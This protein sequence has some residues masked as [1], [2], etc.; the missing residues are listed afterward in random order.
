MQWIGSVP[1]GVFSLRSANSGSGLNNRHSQVICNVEDSDF[2]ERSITFDTSKT[3]PKADENR[4]FN[5][6]MTPTIYLGV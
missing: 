1:Y 4:P 5:I 3:V 2:S 6:G